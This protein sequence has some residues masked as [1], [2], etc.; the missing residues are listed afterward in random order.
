[1]NRR[2]LLTACALTTLGL[3]LPSA[4]RGEEKIKALMITQSQGFVHDSVKRMEQTLAPA[5]VAMIQLGQKMGNLEVH[6]SQ[7]CA[8]DFT[9]EN[10]QNY[11]LVMFYT[12]GNLPIKPDDLDYFFNDWMKR[13]GNGFIGFHS[14]SDTFHEY[15][16]YWDFIGGTF[17][18]HPWNAG[19]T[20]TLS[21]HDTNFPAMKPLGEKFQIRDE[22][23]QYKNWQPEK[24]R[25]LMS[26]NM[27]E[28]SV[29]RPYHVPVAWAKEYGQGRMFYTNL[30]HNPETW[31]N[32]KF[33]ASVEQGILW[34]LGLIDGDATP[35][36]ELS[37]AQEA[38]AKA[39]V[40]E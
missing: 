13:K 12:T 37:K 15:K 19:G 26:I 8:S 32:P 24:V 1:V 14:A 21:V 5:E 23:Y 9:R 39:D 2:S 30:G 22:I 27:A 20:V 33:L 17:N 10:L 29:K 25:V 40:G 35:N 31:T 34:S 18:G 6:C 4:T 7:D 16:P 3:L 36:P 11:R 38:K 28:T